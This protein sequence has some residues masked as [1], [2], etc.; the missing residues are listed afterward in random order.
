MIINEN[1]KLHTLITSYIKE[2][3]KTKE[4]GI[5]DV[6]SP[7]V[8]LFTI[9]NQLPD[10]VKS[11]ELLCSLDREK[12][13]ILLV[14]D[15][16]CDGLN[17]LVVG[18]SIL[19]MLKYNVI[20]LCNSRIN[21]YGFNKTLIKNINDKL[22]EHKNIKVIIGSDHGSSDKEALEELNKKCKVILTDHHE[23]PKDINVHSFVN[24]KNPKRN[25]NNVLTT[26]VNGTCVVF[27]TLYHFA[28]TISSSIGVL[29][30]DMLELLFEKVGF[31]LALSIIS[32]IMDLSD[33]TNRYLY[34]NGLCFGSKNSF[35]KNLIFDQPH[36]GGSVITHKFLGQRIAPIINTGNRLNLEE[37]AYKTLLGG[38]SGSLELP[39]L[40]CANNHRK[41]K[42]NKVYDHIKLE[43]N[44]RILKTQKGFIPFQ[45]VKICEIKDV[46]TSDEI[47]I[48]NLIIVE[49][50]YGNFNI[51]SALAS[52]IAEEYKRCSIVFLSIVK[53]E[54][55]LNKKIDR[56][57]GSCRGYGGI[58]ILE[59][60]K[61][62]KPARLG[63]H[64]EACGVE[65]E[66]KDLPKFSKILLSK[67]NLKKEFSKTIVL[68][69]EYKDLEEDQDICDKVISLLEPC[70]KNFPL[71]YFKIDVFIDKI[72]FLN[73]TIEIYIQK[74]A[75]KEE[76]QPNLPKH[77]YY[78][79]NSVI[80][81]RKN[82]SFHKDLGVGVKGLKKFDF[83]N[84]KEFGILQQL[85]T[86]TLIFTT[87]IE[88]GKGWYEIGEL[89]YDENKVEN[90]MPGYIIM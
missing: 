8:D 28:Y 89:F 75:V 19:S 30:E 48:I 17:S 32:D 64:K 10:I 73:N 76:F 90:F 22:K 59:L 24:P 36:L 7:K 29:Q 46:Y 84:K 78:N 88:R 74:Y 57:H 14:S 79:I 31:N 26:E 16:D 67:K 85:K 87:L 71:P 9:A 4:L 21:G 5:Q 63:G 51:G 43:L 38:T 35:L 3:G 62:T 13:A 2:I 50:D 44:H 81:F 42:S 49:S 45:P 47:I 53:D 65:I 68:P 23:V 25:P 15:Y 82:L 60:L 55:E 20:T 70:G 34:K 58:N 1:S 80:C 6:V 83:S 39:T 27:L 66:Y 72:V 11:T 61:E 33:I 52:R 56:I 40:I 18:K 54:D 12:D 37:T 41:Q 86:A 69:I 77:K